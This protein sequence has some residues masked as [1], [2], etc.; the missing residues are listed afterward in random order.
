MKTFIAFY[1]KR[2]LFLGVLLGLSVFSL[3]TWQ[4]AAQNSKGDY[5]GSISDRPFVTPGYKTRKIAADKESGRDSKDE[6][7]AI[8]IKDAPLTCPTTFTQSSSQ[9]VAGGNSFSCN[10]GAPNFFHRENSYWR[11]FNV[12]GLGVS[13]SETYTISSVDFAIEEANA[14]GV[15]TTQPV[16]VRL[17]A[18]NGAAFPGGT[19]TQ[20]GIANLDV[21]DQTGTVLNVPIAA[22]IAP[23]TFE[24]V[25]EV[26]TPDGS[27]AGH[28]FFIG[29]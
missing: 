21:V 19:Q 14:A 16:T 2:L 6:L 5:A 15:G 24:L 7:P 17:Y 12:A 25:M 9:A 20:I 22:V 10:T 4:V 26:F 8:E 18:N 3:V 13:A 23:G 27:V 1:K 11:A 28:K 29:S